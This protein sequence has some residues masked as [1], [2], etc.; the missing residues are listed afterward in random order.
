MPLELEGRRHGTSARSRKPCRT[1]ANPRACGVHP[2]HSS[3]YEN[4]LC[5]FGLVTK[6]EVLGWLEQ[7]MVCC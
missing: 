1:K 5:T 2:A 7:R 3:Y 6:V 4:S